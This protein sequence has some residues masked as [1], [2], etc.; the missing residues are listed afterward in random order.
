MADHDP[1]PTTGMAGA[2]ER[3]KTALQIGGQGNRG[4]FL[5]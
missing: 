5:G 4:A 1:P 2:E 3:D